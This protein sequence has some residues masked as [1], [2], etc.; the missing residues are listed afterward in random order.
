MNID[1]IKD[2]VPGK[3]RL[4]GWIN[5]SEVV[6]VFY[7]ID[8][9]TGN[10]YCQDKDNR[11]AYVIGQATLDDWVIELLSQQDND[12]GDQVRTPIKNY[13]PEY[14]VLPDPTTKEVIIIAADDRPLTLD[15]V[16]EWFFNV[17]DGDWQRVNAYNELYKLFTLG[18]NIEYDL[19]GLLDIERKSKPWK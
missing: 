3:T 16:G 6:V 15:N 5:Q 13:I 17:G 11:G 8:K 1:D 12:P 14:V 19:K 9:L 7:F 2:L 10:L 4:I 18:D